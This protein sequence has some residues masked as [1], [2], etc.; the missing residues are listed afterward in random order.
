MP[1]NLKQIRDW[2][3][4]AQEDMNRPIGEVSKNGAHRKFMVN[5]LPIVFTLLDYIDRLYGQVN[6][7][8]N[9]CYSKEEIKRII[10]TVT[11]DA[12]ALGEYKYA[13]GYEQA[14]RDALAKFQ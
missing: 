8:P 2:A 5:S 11:T 7:I 6:A 1:L 10:E 4:E 14:I 13:Q 12:A 3:N 9:P